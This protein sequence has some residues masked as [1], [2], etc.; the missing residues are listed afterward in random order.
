MYLSASRRG[1]RPSQSMY[2]TSPPPNTQDDH[3][4]LSGSEENIR[5]NLNSDSFISENSS[6][7]AKV[8][9]F[10]HSSVDIN[11]NVF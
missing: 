7:G 6:V 1:V 3:T 9:S 2:V 11:D 4:Y 8:V 5:M 10:R